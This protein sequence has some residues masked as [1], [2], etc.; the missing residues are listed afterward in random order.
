MSGGN[1]PMVA[2]GSI[3]LINTELHLFRDLFRNWELEGGKGRML[4]NGEEL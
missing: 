3:L 2:L 1:M 4:N